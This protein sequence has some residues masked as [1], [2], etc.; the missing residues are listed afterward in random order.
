MKTATVKEAQEHLS[1]LLRQVERGETVEITRRSRAIARI[2]PAH[3]S[4]ESVSWDN[5]MR[6]LR[7][8]YGPKPVRGKKGS[9]IISEG[10]E[11]KF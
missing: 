9:A 11:K 10:R 5:R 1:E 6:E 3:V 4:T 7:A 2:V 8:I